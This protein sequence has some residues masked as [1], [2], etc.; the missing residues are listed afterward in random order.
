MSYLKRS[1][2]IGEKL[3]EI[4]VGRNETLVNTSHPKILLVQFDNGHI[5]REMLMVS[6]Q[7]RFQEAMQHRE[8]VLSRVMEQVPEEA[9]MAIQR[10]I[11]APPDES[12]CMCNKM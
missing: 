12:D 4:L 6:S 9:K 11:N 5:D 3:E 2:E 7:E 10:A 8:Q 1:Q